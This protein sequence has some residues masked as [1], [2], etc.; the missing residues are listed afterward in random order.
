VSL[1]CCASA[2]SQAPQLQLPAGIAYDAAGNLYISD[3]NRNQVLE[4][5]L[6]GRLIVVA[7]TGTQ[8]FGG[9]SG[10]A[11]AAELNAPQGIALGP[12]GTLYIADTGNH[13]IRAVS[14]GQIT[15][16][17]GTGAAGY[18]G[19]GAAPT[20]AALRS[21]TALALDPAGAL[22]VCDTG[23]HRIRRIANGSITTV[24]GNGTQGFSG[25]GGPATSAELD[26][27]LG[28]AAFGV[29]GFY[30]ADSHNDRI[31]SV[32]LDGTIHTA[33]GTGVRGFS[34]DGGAASQA[35]LAQPRGL[36]LTSAGMVF[37]D[38]N[39][40]RLRRIDGAGM[41]STVVGSGTE[42]NGTDGDATLGASI[43]TPAGLALSPYGMITF[44]DSANRTVRLL[45]SQRLFVPAAMAPVRSSTITA[46]A[47]GTEIY[48]AATLTLGVSGSVG[49]PQGTVQVF[50]GSSLL[51]TASLAGGTASM[52]LPTLSAGAHNLTAAYLGDG[53]NPAVT[54]VAALSIGQAPSVTVESTPQ[55]SG[56]AGLPATL[57]AQVSSTTV[58]RPTGAVQFY[59]GA[60]VVASGQLTAGSVSAIYLNPAVGTHT[61][62][63]V[64]GGDANFQ[65][66]GSATVSLV[67][68]P[69]PD[70]VVSSAVASQTV[71]GG[72][73]A[74]YPITVGS[75]PGPFSGAV[76]LSASGLPSAAS[77]SFTP[78]QVVPGAGTVTVQMSVTTPVTTVQ[79]VP[80]G[81]S[82]PV[83]LSL[84]VLAMA[85]LA[86]RRG[87]RELQL[88]LGGGVSLCLFAVL[89]CGSRSIAAPAV[90][91]VA[92]SITVTGTATNL[93]GA[94]VTHTTVVQLTVR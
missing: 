33:A 79:H 90:G 27:P 24:A 76:I 40:Q 39:N 17:A 21:P 71:Q 37:S 13:R 54:S 93:A 22:L 18:S 15:T 73:I 72:S 85:A 68:Q 92:Y 1:L 67:V 64:Y 77:V 63:A 31:R 74:T 3:T 11:A 36:L 62:R 70:F 60:N 75:Q 38:T 5:T 78:A 42:G 88:L 28:V 29:G 87:R 16:F 84:L 32:G 49:V 52:T 12:D 94:V 41:I 50:D 9:D 19:D 46:T 20:A 58:G 80:P 61:L 25:D 56:Y 26:T 44:V 51:A 7:G 6:A 59:E 83:Q 53:L 2:V 47:A 10:P 86:R 45:S 66:S 30:I 89:G 55:Q 23:N 81:P 57:S 69:M 82:R 14:A 35:K 43:D 4:A 34:G 65:S 91:P 8:G 48:G